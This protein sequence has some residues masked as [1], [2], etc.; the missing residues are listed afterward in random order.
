M[1]IVLYPELPAEIAERVLPSQN[2]LAGR[3]LGGRGPILSGL[4]GYAYMLPRNLPS[5]YGAYG[6]SGYDPIFEARPETQVYRDKMDATPA[7]AARAYGIRWI[8]L[9]TP[10]I[11][12]KDADYWSTMRKGRFGGFTDST[13]PTYR[14]KS[15]PDAKWLFS[16]EEVSLYELPDPSLWHSIERILGCCCRLRVSWSAPRCKFLVRALG[17]S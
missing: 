1:A 6:Y 5:A 11:G 10:T 2:P 17:P 8:L 4:P 15:F 16:R 9:A 3:V 14:E 7:E 13:W 12:K